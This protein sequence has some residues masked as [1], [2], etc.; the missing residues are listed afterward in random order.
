MDE[1]RERRRLIS[2]TSKDI[3]ELLVGKEI[4]VQEALEILGEAANKMTCIS[5]CNLDFKGPFWDRI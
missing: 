2:D 3:C 4:S 1:N 5:S